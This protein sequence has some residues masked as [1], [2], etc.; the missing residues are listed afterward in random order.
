MV[1]LVVPKFWE[2]TTRNEFRQRR[3]ILRQ[4]Y[5]SMNIVKVEY[6][7]SGGGDEG[8]LEDVNYWDVN[9]QRVNI[10]ENCLL[11]DCVYEWICPK[12][13][14]KFPDPIPRV[15]YRNL[16]QIESELGFGLMEI[17]GEDGWWNDTGG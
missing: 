6:S 11:P 12:Q 3:R 17:C 2:N 9:N 16:W 1:E 7:Y 14:M 15:N 10:P 13:R 8:S 4:A 5:M